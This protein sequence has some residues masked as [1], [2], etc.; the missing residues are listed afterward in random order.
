MTIFGYI[1]TDAEQEILDLGSISQIELMQAS[2]TRL[3]SDQRG[4]LKQETERVLDQ[5]Y[6]LRSTYRAIEREHRA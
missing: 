2:L 3:F 4:V 6:A 1:D 5:M